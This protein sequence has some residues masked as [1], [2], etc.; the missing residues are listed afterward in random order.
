[1]VFGLLVGVGF[2]LET[3]WGIGGFVLWGRNADWDEFA[4]DQLFFRAKYFFDW[5]EDTA[6]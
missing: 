1:V 2:F 5:A 4:P 3:N 6:R